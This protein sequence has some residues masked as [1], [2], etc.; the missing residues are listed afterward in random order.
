MQHS[1]F[2]N[3][4]FENGIDDNLS[5]CPSSSTLIHVRFKIIT[6]QRTFEQCWRNICFYARLLGQNKKR[7]RI[8]ICFFNKA[9]IMVNRQQKSLMMFFICFII[10]NFTFIFSLVMNLPRQFKINNL[11]TLVFVKIPLISLNHLCNDD[12]SLLYKYIARKKNYRDLYMRK[13]LFRIIIFVALP[14]SLVIS[15]LNHINYRIFYEDEDI[16]YL[17]WYFSKYKF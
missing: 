7:Y 3:L 6:I 8:C 16:S 4:N 2:F 1:S 9:R 13:K 12:D 15:F 17:F 10:I 14:T 5:K 11:S